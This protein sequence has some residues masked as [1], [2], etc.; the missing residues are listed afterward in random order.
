MFI[1]IEG[2]DGAGKTTQCD[3]LQQFF[4]QHEVN[5]LVVREPAGTEFGKRLKDL[6]MSDV[7]RGELTELFSFL[8][9]KAQLY[10]QIIAPALAA[11]KYV[12]ADRGSMSFL[13]Y[14]HIA[15]GM[16]FDQLGK[17]METATKERSPHLTILLDVPAE[18]A[19]ARTRERG[20]ISPFDK[21]SLDYYET[22]RRVFLELSRTLHRCILVDGTP[23]RE[24]IN[25]QIRSE[26]SIAED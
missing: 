23:P 17:L 9:A 20:A 8:A 6:I 4:E 26:L 16:G 5:P 25:V 2:I 18:T 11:G 7:P 22:Q 15:T 24:D 3:L 1:E 21:R 19:M 10:T 13:S 14:H 12:I